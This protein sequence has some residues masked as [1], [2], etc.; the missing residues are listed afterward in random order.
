MNSVMLE[1]FAVDRAGN[2]TNCKNKGDP[3][4]NS[5]AWN[6]RSKMPDQAYSLLSLPGFD[7]PFAKK[8]S[9]QV[10][11]GMSRSTERLHKCECTFVPD[12]L[13]PQLS[14]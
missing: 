3:N 1:R 7:E 9:E 4:V 10:K 14:A 5:K 6:H 11:F 8:P 2:S 13:S 12:R